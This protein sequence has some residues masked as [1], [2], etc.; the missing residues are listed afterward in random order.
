MIRRLG[1]LADTRE[2]VPIEYIDVTRAV[3]RML[4]SHAVTVAYRG[5]SL[6]IAGIVADE[7]LKAGGRVIGVTV[8]GQE[9][10]ELPHLGLSEL[11]VVPSE[12]DRQREIGDLADGFLVLP[13][14]P[15]TLS[16]AFDVW[17]WG[18]Q[19]LRQKPL[20]LLNTNDYFTHQLAGV[21][22]ALVDQFVRE[23]QRG[24]LVVSTGPEDLLR[25]LADFRPPETRRATSCDDE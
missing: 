21:D 11:R 12:A 13:G 7:A 6:G 4:A 19:G 18:T 2:T 10:R 16:D 8:E 22:D 3:A 9:E 5:G 25:R 17:T 1:I 23:S 14:W 15:G 20:G 24:M